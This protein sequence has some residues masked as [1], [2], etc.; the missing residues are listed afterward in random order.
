MI[1]NLWKSPEAFCRQTLH[2][3]VS[4]KTSSHQNSCTALLQSV[5]NSA[6]HIFRA[7]SS[8]VHFSCACGLVCSSQH[9]LCPAPFL[10]SRAIRA[11]ALS[12]NPSLRVVRQSVLAR[13]SAAFPSAF[14]GA[15]TRSTRSIDEQ[16]RRSVATLRV[17]RFQRY[18]QSFHSV[19]EYMDISL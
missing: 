8:L 9:N 17:Q 6:L 10:I 14:G 3:E 11:C 15:C 7:V 2:V 5:Q 1:L 4:N 13:C 18:R 16:W 19:I 12:D